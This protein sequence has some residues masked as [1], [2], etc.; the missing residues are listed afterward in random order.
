MT[1]DFGKRFGLGTLRLPLKDPADQKSIDYDQFCEMI[2]KFLDHGFRYFDTSYIYHDN[3][4]EIALRECLVK[5]YPRDA[6]LL[7]D[8]LP[9][10]FMDVKFLKAREDMERM[11]QHQLD[12]CGVDYFDFYLIHSITSQGY[13]ECNEWGAFEFL[14]EARAAGKFREFGVSLHD[15]PEFLDQILTEHPEIDF[16]VLQINYLDWESPT[17]RSRELYE[18]ALKHGKPVV[19]MEV[20]KGGM[21]AEVPDEAKAL[22]KAYNPDA[23]IASWAY[24]FTASLPNVRV[25][26][27]ST[28]KMEFMDDNIETMEN[29]EPLNDEEYEIL[30][31]V[32]EIVNASI[33]IPCTECRYCEQGCPKNIDIPDYFGLYNDLK[34]LTKSSYFNPVRT[35]QINYA[36]YVEAGRGAASECIGCKKCEKVCPQGLPIVDYLKD[37]V[38]EFEEWTPA[39]EGIGSD[40]AGFSSV[41]DA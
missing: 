34:A 18:T 16:V 37:V 28:P 39:D 25:V 41:V 4:S 20:C 23:S 36:N 30:H 5:R 19:A 11:L 7:S 31:K 10:K 22:M 1:I 32:V 17:I 9:I 24:R 13:K 6:F 15:T 35:Q 38:R 2:D 8:K 33:A 27:T 40:A 29:F 3:T 14:S 26:L 21:L 12:K